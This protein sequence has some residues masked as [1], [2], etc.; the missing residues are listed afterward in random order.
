MKAFVLL[1]FFQVLTLG[2]HGQSIEN[3]LI[4]AKEFIV[5]GE[6][7]DNGLG[8]L[9]VEADCFDNIVVAGTYHGGPNSFISWGG[10]TLYSQGNNS[11]DVFLA[12]MDSNGVILWH[13][14]IGGGKSDRLSGI[15]IDN[16]NNIIA[17]L[18]CQDTFTFMGV[19]IKPGNNLLKFNED[20]QIQWSLNI[21]GAQHTYWSPT[22]FNGP[23]KQMSITEQNEII[24]GGSVPKVSDF[25]VILDTFIHGPDTFF[26]YL[27]VYDTLNVGGQIFTVDTNNIFVA[28]I[29][30]L[31]SLQWLKIFEHNGIISLSSLDAAKN[32]EINIL[33][34]FQLE[35]WSVGGAFLTVDTF[36][37]L[38]KKNSY[39]LKLDNSGNVIWANKYYRNIIPRNLLT[40]NLGNIIASGFFQPFTYYG[41]DTI[42]SNGL[43]S[44]ILLFKVDSTG[45]LLWGTRVGDQATNSFVYII[46]NSEDEIFLSGDIG[47]V[48]GSIM[49]KYSPAGALLWEVKPSQSS[50][51]YGGDIALDHSGNLIQTGIH[52]GG[53]V[54]GNDTL[55]NDF[56]NFWHLFLLKFA[57]QSEPES[58]IVCGGGGVSNVENLGENFAFEIFPNPSTGPLN[59]KFHFP[60]ETCLSITL[61]DLNG[62]LLDEKVLPS[63]K[64]EVYTLDFISQIPGP[65]ILKLSNDQFVFSK[66]VIFTK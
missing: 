5:K 29:S 19:K 11:N 37:Y 33:G 40:D 56:S 3:N 61:L 6:Y 39:I 10:D 16:E 18:W 22:A 2:I 8:N 25:S 38:Y 50:N 13:I 44:D 23:G 27:Q 49:N 32:Q 30:P 47:S 43:A 34:N 63:I 66:L 41:Q 62:K 20:A 45:Q 65:Y 17:Y 31:G 64:N 24:L 36:Q 51:R 60:S 1:L 4:W 15:R 26:Q 28:K 48:T 53:L 55:Y 54:I 14:L 52:A 46:P 59:L 21:E 58:N 7:T 12:K 57:N 42:Y 9:L 35:S